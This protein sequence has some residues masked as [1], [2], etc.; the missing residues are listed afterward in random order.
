MV[1]VF[2]SVSAVESLV[3]SMLF[4]ALL[5]LPLFALT[6]ASA[7]TVD[8]VS[9]GARCND[10]DDSAAVQAAINAV[11]NGGTV[12][13]PCLAGIGSRGISLQ[14][15]GPCHH[16]RH[17]WGRIQVTWSHSQLHFRHKLE[18]RAACC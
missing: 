9:F 3:G 18:L 11:P 5:M 6:P 12:R 14:N 2:K 8:I 7:Q 15:Q 4:P 10:G 17:E 13:V 1:S 16:R